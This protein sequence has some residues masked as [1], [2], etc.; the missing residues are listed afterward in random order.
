[1]WQVQVVQVDVEGRGLTIYNVHMPGWSAWHHFEPDTPFMDQIG[2]SIRPSVQ[3]DVEARNELA[4]WLLDDIA[5]RSNPAIVLGDFN[6]TDQSDVYCILTERLTDAHRV[7]GW[8]FGHTF[9]AY[10]GW[11]QGIP[12]VPRQ[13]RIDMI[14]YSRDL[15]ALR[16]RVGS[17]HGE[18]DH[19]PVM[20]ELIWRK[21][22]SPSN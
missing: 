22:G 18:S 9:P 5:G 4:R 3:A 1:M 12:I 14:L 15:Q 8:G 13:V 19:L 20:A 17:A 7:A 2:I 11:Y 16:S 21:W 6:S 10:R